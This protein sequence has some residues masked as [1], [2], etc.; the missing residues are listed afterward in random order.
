MSEKAAILRNA[1]GYFNNDPLTANVWLDK[2]ALRNRNGEVL[3]FDPGWTIGR[4]CK[5]F[6]RIEKKYKNPLSFD[7]IYEY[8]DE[9]KYIIPAG[10]P[11]FGIGNKHSLSTLSNCYVIQAPVDSYGGIL[12][13]DEELVQLA[14]RRGGIGFDISTLR[15]AGSNVSNSA[16]TSTGVQLFMERYSNSTR[17][18]AQ[19]GRRGALILTIKID[20]PDIKQFI[21]AKD[22]LSKVTGANISVKITDKFMHAVENDEMFDLGPD[23]QIK[24]KELWDLIVHQAWKNGEPG[25]ILW[26]NVIKESP[27][28]CYK[29]FRTVSTNPCSELPLCEYDSCRLMHVNTYSFVINP[30]EKVSMFNFKGFYRAVFVAQRLMDD[31]VDLEEEKILEIIKKIDRDP[32]EK[33]LKQREKDLWLKILYKLRQGRRTGLNPLL[34]LADTLA[35]LGIKYDSDEAIDFTEKISKMGAVATYD[36]SIQLAKERGAFPAFNKKREIANPFLNRLNVAGIK[37]RNIS[38]LTV[39][40]SGSISMLA[41]VSSGIEPVFNLHYTRKRKVT[42]ESQNKAFRD[43]LGDWWEEY[44]IFHPKLLKWAEIALKTDSTEVILNNVDKSP[45]FG[46]T[47]NEIDPFKK[48]K[49]QATIQRWIDHSISITYNFPENVKKEV[50][51]DLYFQAW[52]EG[53]KGLTVYREGSR[54]GVL[55]NKKKIEFSDHDAPKRPKV[56]PHDVYSIM[57]KGHHWVVCVGFLE[58]KPYEVFAFN[59]VELPGSKFTGQIEKFTKGRYDLTIPSISKTYNNITES[60]SD[61]ENLLTRMISTSLRH[62]ANIRFVVEQLDK[63]KGDITSFGRGIARVLKKYIPNYTTKSNCPVCNNLLQYEGGCQVC[64]HCGHSKCD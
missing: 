6:A 41:Q 32:E 18:V 14:K 49:L 22:D 26:D 16:G 59:N 62:G 39:P 53:L 50:I 45:Y 31:I 40:P 15:P 37:R 30:F 52:K 10:S 56:L 33:S 43:K 11:L 17:E 42:E 23:V 36:S 20:H 13:T 7:E 47:A 24:A 48:L 9:F 1:I 4:L 3:E 57:S 25:L 55:I 64:K 63:S 5:E 44:T 61:E 27:A 58:E 28:D 19:D 60:C 46:A 8:L 54:D 35:A 2:Y 29:G 21:T 51:S 12:K 34:G 38:C